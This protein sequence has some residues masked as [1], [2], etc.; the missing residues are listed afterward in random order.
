MTIIKRSRGIRNLSTQSSENDE[1]SPYQLHIDNGSYLRLA[2]SP[3]LEAAYRIDLHRLALRA[4]LV[5]GT[6]LAVLV[7]TIPLLDHFIFHPPE[8]FVAPVRLMQFGL[9]MP[10]IAAT[11]LASLNERLQ[12]YSTP[13]AASALA[14]VALCV[15]YQRVLGYELGYY[16]AV[17]WANVAIIGAFFFAGIRTTQVVPLGVA[18][19]SLNF[20]A[21]LYVGNYS[22][23]SSALIN[24][25]YE[26]E[27]MIVIFILGVAG[28]YLIETNTRLNWLETKEMQQQ[29]DYDDLTGALNRGK[30]R[31]VYR[32]LFSMAQREQ[33]DISIAI[34]DIDFFKA[35]NDHYGHAPGDKCLTLIGNCLNT[36]ADKNGGYCA[37]LGGEEFALLFFGMNFLEA[38][39]LLSRICQDVDALAIAHAGRP[40]EHPNVTVSIGGYSLIPDGRVNRFVALRKADK[41]LYAAKSQG[42]NQLVMVESK[43]APH[44]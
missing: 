18:L 4:R 12:A 38:Q 19:F 7:L 8:A 29:L 31:M 3:E 25:V 40:D 27:G 34:V 10:L 14:A 30:F 44:G 9:L 5:F 33:R 36:A 20:A 26:L 42:R 16:T 13:I 11:I 22:S 21:E 15:I 2:F 28:C 43:V 39:S 1:R 35:Y 37:R 23:G 24:T 41:S 6:L 32:R 17:G